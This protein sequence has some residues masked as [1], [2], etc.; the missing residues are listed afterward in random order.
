M[1]AHAGGQKPI[2]ED[3]STI[4]GSSIKAKQRSAPSNGKDALEASRPRQEPLPVSSRYL[5]ARIE[6]A[7]R[8]ASARHQASPIRA[9]RREYAVVP[10]QVGARLRHQRRK[11]RDL[12][13][14]V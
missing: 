13:S 8:G 14:S 6:A 7:E 9:C 12:L 3:R 10:R 1:A 11:A 2:A 5:A 4:S